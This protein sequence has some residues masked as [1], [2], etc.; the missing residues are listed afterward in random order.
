MPDPIA[1]L[2]ARPDV[3][4]S[5]PA[6]PADIEAVAR[7]FGGPLPD[8]LVR[9]WRAADGADLGPIDARLLGAAQSLAIVQ[10]AEAD[11][12]DWLA[13]NFPPGYL[14][15]AADEAKANYLCAYLAGP[16]TPRVVYLPHHPGDRLLYRTVAGLFRD[17]PT[18]L[19]RRASFEAFFDEV[20]GDYGRDSTRDARDRADGRALL[21][22]EQTL[23]GRRC[24]AALLGAGDLDGWEILLDGG[25]HVRRFALDR[26]EAMDAP[27]VR[28]LIARHRREFAAFVDVVAGAAL[29]A[30]LTVG[31]RREDGLELGGMFCNLEDE[32]ARR[33]RSETIAE[34]I[35][36]Q[37]WLL[38][39]IRSGPGR[40]PS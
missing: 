24:A 4:P 40:P 8:D 19:D 22:D 27:A 25:S 37:R 5:P 16:L 31:G 14:P 30:G 2:L 26:L 17:L 15:V 36:K 39:A 3:R 28:D 18:L 20:P 1:H 32:F 33:E 29:A 9:F 38:G 7:H 23:F 35:N 10:R 21:A 6:A 34:L 13:R 12:D 11:P